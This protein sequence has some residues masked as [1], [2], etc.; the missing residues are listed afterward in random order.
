[1]L[2]PELPAAANTS[3]L[4]VL[5]IALIWVSSVRVKLDAPRLMETTRAP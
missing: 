2:V 1:V 4:R 3:M 5:N